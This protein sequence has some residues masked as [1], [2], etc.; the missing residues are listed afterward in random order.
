MHV[1][2]TFNNRHNNHWT[3][4]NSIS[5]ASRIK[6]HFTGLA[7]VFLTLIKSLLSF[8]VFI[9]A[10]F[11]ITRKPQCLQQDLPSFTRVLANGQKVGWKIKLGSLSMTSMTN[12]ASSA[13]AI[14]NLL[15]WAL[16][17]A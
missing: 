17:I 7:C 6:N 5:A 12:T 16:E 3:S 2:V 4:F 14:C 10:T 15:S 11:S 1:N 8:A 9:I 13:S